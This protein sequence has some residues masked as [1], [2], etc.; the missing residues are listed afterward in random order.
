MMSVPNR[1]RWGR[2]WSVSADVR[3]CVPEGYT[4]N[5]GDRGRCRNRRS[6]GH[7]RQAFEALH[8]ALIQEMIEE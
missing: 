3:Y 1:T 4:I 2:L 5:M 7:A 6:V 8:V